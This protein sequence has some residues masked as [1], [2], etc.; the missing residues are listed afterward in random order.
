MLFDLER[1]FFILNDYFHTQ[2]IPP[3]TT[4]ITKKKT[5]PR[6]SPIVF[7]VVLLLFKKNR[8]TDKHTPNNSSEAKKNGNRIDLIFKNRIHLFIIRS[9]LI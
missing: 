7:K 5:E 6:P 3:L 1:I 8:Q 9:S 2:Y 4:Q